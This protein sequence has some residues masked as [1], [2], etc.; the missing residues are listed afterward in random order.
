[1][2]IAAFAPLAAAIY[3][4]TSVAWTLAERRLFLRRT[5]PA[6]APGTVTASAP[7]KAAA[8]TPSRR[9]VKTVP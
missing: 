2:V 1:V 7:G 3:L 5:A 9:R 4:V 8:P 6:P